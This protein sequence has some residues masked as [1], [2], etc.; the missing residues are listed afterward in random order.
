MA[1]A[2][3]EEGRAGGGGPPGG[4]PPQLLA[5]P[6]VAAPVSSWRR[7]EASGA[8][9][10]TAAAVNSDVLVTG[11]PHPGSVDWLHHA[12][13]FCFS[14][15][16]GP[17]E[18][19]VEGAFRRCRY[20]GQCASEVLSEGLSRLPAPLAAD[21]LEELLGWWSRRCWE[22]RRTKEAAEAIKRCGGKLERAFTALCGPAGVG[23]LPP[24]GGR[25]TRPAPCQGAA[26]SSTACGIAAARREALRR[27]PP[28]PPPRTPQAAA[29]WTPLRWWRPAAATGLAQGGRAVRAAGLAAE[30]LRAPLGPHA[31][32]GP[33]RSL[34]A[35]W[36]RDRAGPGARD[37]LTACQDA[38]RALSSGLA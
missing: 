6:A 14:A 11:G 3:A 8:V 10:K 26:A 24:R 7:D 2:A 5:S 13:S 29:A 19:A 9:V 27:R 4:P 28:R 15:P 21:E 20:D 33:R 38:L 1:P 36:Y 12:G 30:A 17:R 32:R 31:R 35:G 22:D 37:A 34:A 18:A 23:S 16:S 25:A